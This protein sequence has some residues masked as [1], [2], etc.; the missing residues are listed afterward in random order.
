MKILKLRLQN[1]NSIRCEQ[2]VEIDFAGGRIGEEGIFAITGET[3]AGKSTLLDAICLALYGATPRFPGQNTPDDEVLSHGTGFAMAEVDYSVD[4]QIPGG[5]ETE[6]Y[7]SRWTV[8][9]ANKKPDG[10]LQAQKMVLQRIGT[11]TLLCS[12]KDEVKKQ[13]GKILG[14]EFPNF[15][16][17]VLLAQG[18][19]SLFLKGSANDRASILERIT[20]TK[21]F[22]QIS[23]AC[24]SKCMRERTVL[25]GLENQASAITRLTEEERSTLQE[26]HKLH[27]ARAEELREQGDQLAIL[28]MLIQQH[29]E[30][31]G[32]QKHT[33]DEL[34]RL[35]E[36]EEN[37]EQD[38]V[39]LR[40]YDVLSPFEP[41]LRE[42]Q[43]GRTQLQALQDRISTLAT[44]ELPR[45]E[46]DLLD[47]EGAA[48]AAKELLTAVV[49]ERADLQLLCKE[50]RGLDA[51]LLQ[52]QEGLNQKQIQAKDKRQELTNLGELATV[53]QANLTNQEQELASIQDWL[54]AHAQDANLH[55]HLSGITGDLEQLAGLI[56]KASDQTVHLAGLATNVGEQ[57]QK[58]AEATE[59]LNQ[60]RLD[61]TTHA[62]LLQAA[63]GEL[64]TA[65]E[66]QTTQSLDQAR[67]A[68]AEAQAQLLGVVAKVQKLGE[69]A[70]ALNGQI[71]EHSTAGAAS[72]ALQAELT[73]EQENQAR[74]NAAVAAQSGR[75]NEQ[76]S[77]KGMEQYRADLRDGEECPCCGA[78]EHPYASELPADNLAE[79]E[80]ALQRLQSEL[81]ACKSTLYQKTAL[82]AQREER[83]QL[84]KPLIKAG[85]EQVAAGLAA[86]LE[87][88]KPGPGATEPA[89]IATWCQ[90]QERSLQGQQAALKRAMAGRKDLRDKLAKL[91]GRVTLLRE[92]AAELNKKIGTLEGAE[93]HHRSEHSLA[94]ELFGQL[95][96]QVQ[97]VLA[98]REAKR[99]ALAGVLEP[100]GFASECLAKP[101]LIKAGLQERVQIHQTRIATQN[102][103]TVAAGLEQGKLTTN[104]TQQSTLKTS[105]EELDEDLRLRGIA[106]QGLTDQRQAKLQDRVV[107]EV[108]SHFEKTVDR[109]RENEK[110]TAAK[111]LLL[112][113]SVKAMEQELTQKRNDA[114]AATTALA[115][116][117]KL[118]KV[119]VAQLDLA[120]LPATTESAEHILGETTAAAT[121]RRAQIGKLRTL[122]SDLDLARAGLIA[123]LNNLQDAI[124]RDPLPKDE[125]RSLEDL[126][127]AGD[128][129]RGEEDTATRQANEAQ[130][131]LD[132]DHEK[133]LLGQDL[134]QQVATQTAVVNRWNNLNALIG[135]K[136]GNCFKKV[137]QALNLRNLVIRANGHL[138]GFNNRYVLFTD[139]VYSSM[140]LQI[141]DLDLS[142]KIRSVNNLSGGES[143][144]V[145]LALALG[146]SEMHGGS[147]GIDTLL[148]DEGFGTLDDQT[149]IRVMEALKSLKRA[150]KTVGLISHVHDIREFIPVGIHVKKHPGG[151]GEVTF[152]P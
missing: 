129:L 37:G 142:E 23:M 49:R 60:A 5:V 69:Q 39:L 101:E 41:A 20:D 128:E 93:R 143:F 112:A 106:C 68:E 108:L 84:L 151:L 2:P 58:L 42:L 149:R 3:G 148:I 105:L 13:N 25:E 57:G 113:Q 115:Q 72:L 102:R 61:L 79:A 75:V 59:L 62:Q 95:E 124:D 28:A 4:K 131:T 34:G 147:Q 27:K 114:T 43:Q 121:E 132:R 74:L 30:W 119:Q 88:L 65:G 22:S 46:A 83:L 15:T 110:T 40:Q 85:Q 32:Q 7:R 146:L 100:L 134:S 50:V 6:C 123:A 87:T 36:Q 19:F 63:E 133:A 38:W 54:E 26:D 86:A 35:K 64:A 127:A 9:R 89:T 92:E 122:R 33:L 56:Q 120:P 97:G 80:G 1:L 109:A 125:H 139:A 126:K 47:T 94:K 140:E 90:E 91:E 99:E 14:L 81:E 11:D 8:Q 144:Q 78:L 145:S 104:A 76:R 111:V 24:Y 107:D 55:L 67:A 44:T 150:G 73:T 96:V 53:L 18:D 12:G 135:S 130:A 98:E 136:D 31:A 82:R 66:G 17:A 152:V 137:A 117:E 48:E 103:L 45:A 71:S 21:E 29:A 51:Q 141:Q 10:K 77:R 16:R 116:S 52:A 70:E 118:L 138:M